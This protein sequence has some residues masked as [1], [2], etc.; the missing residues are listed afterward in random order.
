MDVLDHYASVCIVALEW[1]EQ[2]ENCRTS[3][4]L[5]FL[6]WIDVYDCLPNYIDLKF[7]VLSFHSK[8][9]DSS[10]WEKKHELVE[11]VQAKTK[12]MLIDH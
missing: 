10:L 3:A 9:S 4:L 6:L 1:T 2:L 8:D 12:A 7:H 11:K 5:I